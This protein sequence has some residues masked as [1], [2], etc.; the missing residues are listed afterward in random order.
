LIAILLRRRE[1]INPVRQK[2]VSDINQ[3]NEAGGLFIVRTFT[4]VNFLAVEGRESYPFAR[5]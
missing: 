2:P 4:G 5:I 1:A 3:S